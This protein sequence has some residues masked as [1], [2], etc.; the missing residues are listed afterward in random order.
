MLKK[1]IIATCMI[2]SSITYANAQT[3]MCFKQNHVDLVTIENT[4]LEGGECASKKSANDMKKEGWTISDIKMTPSSSG[5]DFIYV[6]KKETNLENV[7]EEALMDKLYKKIESEKVAKETAAKEE[8]V[9][10]NKKAGESLYVSKCAICHGE[11]GELK[12]KGV[13]KPINSLDH[14]EFQAAIKDYNVGNNKD[15]GMAIVMRPYAN[16]MDYND[17]KNVY[18]YLKSVNGEK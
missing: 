12:A 10:A 2:I 11:K 13:S 5:T 1:S 15:A 8:I 18:T 3:T 14:N 16:M 7:S 4:R 6:F 17:I 9:S